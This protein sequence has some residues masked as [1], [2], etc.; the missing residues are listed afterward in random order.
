LYLRQ[1]RMKTDEK[2]RTN[3]AEKIKVSLCSVWT[4]RGTSNENGPK[5]CFNDGKT[6][7]GRPRSD[8]IGSVGHIEPFYGQD[9]GVCRWCGRMKPFR[10]PCWCSLTALQTSK[11]R[12]K[13]TKK[14]AKSGIPENKSLFDKHLQPGHWLH[15]PEGGFGPGGCRGHHPPDRGGGLFL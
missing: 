10:E 9:Y 7:T 1:K 3:K 13:N 4:N 11:K 6:G 2:H 14:Y 12:G 15:K 5:S 8:E